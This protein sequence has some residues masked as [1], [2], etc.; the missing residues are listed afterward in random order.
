ML[1][2]KRF[3]LE[4]ATLAVKLIDG[5]KT[6]VTVPAGAIVESARRSPGRARAY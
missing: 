3:R 6:A 1:A 4:R 2:G 5:K